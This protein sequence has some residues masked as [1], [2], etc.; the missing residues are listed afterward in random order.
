MNHPLHL[1]TE[2]MFFMFAEKKTD[3]GN[4]KVNHPR[5]TTINLVHFSPDLE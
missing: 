3:A 1:S 5:S 4:V 2:T